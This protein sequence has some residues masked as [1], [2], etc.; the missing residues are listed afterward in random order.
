[1]GDWKS[2]SGAVEDSSLLGC[3]DVGLG[4]LFL[5][6]HRIVV[7]SLAVSSSPRRQDYFTLKMKAPGSFE[8]SGTTPHSVTSCKT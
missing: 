2:H 7:P 6:F 8:T 4:T 3:D 1:M 5:M